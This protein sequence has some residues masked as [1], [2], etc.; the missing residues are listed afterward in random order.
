MI[1][2]EQDNSDSVEE[3]TMSR[4]EAIVGLAAVGL[5][6]AACGQVPLTPQATKAVSAIDEAFASSD[7]L[8]GAPHD[9]VF[10]ACNSGAPGR[11]LITFRVLDP[12]EDSSLIEE[13]LAVAFFDAQLRAS[14]AVLAGPDA[15]AAG[16]VFGPERGFVGNVHGMGLQN[17]LSRFPVRVLGPTPRHA[18]ADLRVGGAREL[19]QLSLS[20][21]LA[22]GELQQ[23]ILR[24]NPKETT[25]KQA[26][27]VA[28]EHYADRTRSQMIGSFF[29][30]FA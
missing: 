28:V 5:G 6:M 20:V 2:I 8:T 30:L 4:R 7:V 11:N 27:F 19:P 17:D 12:D 16:M 15:C 24:L 3:L 29:H 26:F 23:V 25:R 9:L 10:G 13:L 14:G 1:R 18:I 21:S 22:T